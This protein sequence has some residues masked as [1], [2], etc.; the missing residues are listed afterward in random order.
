MISP[1]AANCAPGAGEAVKAELLALGQEAGP[2]Q[3]ASKLSS[4]WSELKAL[5]AAKDPDAAK[6]EEYAK[7][8]EL[9]A[10]DKERHAAEMKDYTHLKTTKLSPLLAGS[11]PDGNDRSEK[12]DIQP[13]DEDEA[14]ADAAP[15]ETEPEAGIDCVVPA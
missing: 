4:N 1:R 2:T 7:Y 15:M 12:S 3:V 11:V 13:Y 9:A 6:V 14:P 5:A 8:V 10:A